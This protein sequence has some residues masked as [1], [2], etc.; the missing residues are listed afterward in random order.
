MSA[1]S[2]SQLQKITQPPLIVAA[3]KQSGFQRYGFKLMTIL[4]WV[5]FLFLFRVALTPF[6]WFFGVQSLYEMFSYK[7][8]S[9]DF[10]ELMMI[11]LLIV[12][13]IGICLIGWAR[14]NQERFRKNER[15]TKFRSPVPTGEIA[16]FYQVTT[17]FIDDSTQFRRLVLQHTEDGQ[18]LGAEKTFPLPVVPLELVPV[19]R[20]CYSYGAYLLRRDEGLRW[21]VYLD[22]QQLYYGGSFDSCLDFVHSANA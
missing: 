19:E 3:K 10:A 18:L 1:L 15:R 5:V 20:N 22:G 21:S 16:D 13:A 11:Y 14:Y 17:Q 7:V 9:Q 8:E 2:D 6:V 12:A 4:F